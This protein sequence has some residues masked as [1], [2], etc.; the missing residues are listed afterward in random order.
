MNTKPR[1]KRYISRASASAPQS[2]QL[3]ARSGTNRPANGSAAVAADIGIAALELAKRAQAAGLTTLG[4]LLE[5]VA[6]EA[7]AEAAASDWR[8]DT[9]S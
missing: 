3:A 4:Y 2:D 9:K 6:L 1:R 7:G 8:D 5:S